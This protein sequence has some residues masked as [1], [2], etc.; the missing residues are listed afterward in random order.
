MLSEL[1]RFDYWPSLNTRTASL[2]VAGW[3]EKNW[4]KAS[5]WIAPD[6]TPL[7]E[8]EAFI[9]LIWPE[10][11]INP[12]N[13][14]VHQAVSSAQVWHRD[15]RRTDGKPYFDHLF[16]VADQ[17]YQLTTDAD[18]VMAALLHDSIEDQGITSEA[19]DHRFNHDV[20]YMVSALTNDYSDHLP[21]EEKLAAV[22]K[23]TED[24][25]VDD[26]TKLIKLVDRLDNIMD[27]S[28]WKPAR[29]LRYCENTEVLLKALHLEDYFGKS[30]PHLWLSREIMQRV[31]NLREIHK[32]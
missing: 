1:R 4:G 24:N 7:N 25:I 8:T 11:F 31:K 30:S 27:T 9:E 5:Y 32:E 19:L 17:V 13:R 6:G 21:H 3:K 14:I 2:A 23:H 28:G 22:Q 29:I 16:R 10:L 20:A 26:R 15:Q 18:C 12:Y